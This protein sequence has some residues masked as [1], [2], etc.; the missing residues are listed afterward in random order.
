MF[1][2]IFHYPLRTAA[3]KTIKIWNALDGKFVQTLEGH[4]QGI[5]DVAW[6]SDSQ[7][8][9][10]ASDDKTIRIWDANIVSI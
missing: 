9:T 5:S 8:L 4:G 10:S 3:D 1:S 6:S 2:P 7:Y